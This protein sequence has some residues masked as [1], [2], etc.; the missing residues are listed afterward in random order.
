MKKIL[1]LLIFVTSIANAQYSIKGTMTPPDKD[2]WVILYK[3]NGAKQDFVSNSTINVETVN[4]G[5]KSQQIARFELT[6][7]AD[8]EPGE[9]RVTYRNKGAGFVDFLFNK[10]NVEFVFNPTYP[11][12]SIFF[13]KSIEN[14]VYREYLE[15]LPAICRFFTDCIH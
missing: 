9:Y 1:A 12:Q 14:K 3:L 7:P 8:A 5:G 10:E 4:I 13:I 2:D 11:D 15:L 6:L